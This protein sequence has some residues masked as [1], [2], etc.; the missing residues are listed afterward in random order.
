MNLNSD[1][2]EN[3]SISKGALNLESGYVKASTDDAGILTPDIYFSGI[4]GHVE[5]GATVA[6]LDFIGFGNTANAFVLADASDATL[7]C[8][9]I[10]LE[11]GSDGDTI[12]VLFYGYLKAADLL[13][14][15]QASGTVTIDG[16]IANGEI[17]EINGTTYE[18]RNEATAALRTAAL[19][20][21]SDYALDANTALTKGQA[22]TELLAALVLYET[23]VTWSAWATD[24]LTITSTVKDIAA[25]GNAITLSKTGTNIAVSGAT[26]SGGTNGTT[27]FLSDTA[28]DHSLTTGTKTQTLGRALSLRELFFNPDS[29]IEE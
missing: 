12:K 19:T 22:Q 2:V 1:A 14:G 5:I 8:Q 24:V 21:G 28:G 6:I 17:I 18:F 25:T 9:A 4:V 16:N 20:A 23:G 11:A 7:P 10:A 27:I 13:F 3:L 15:V 26:L 29:Y